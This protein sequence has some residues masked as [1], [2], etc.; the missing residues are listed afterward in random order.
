MKNVGIL[1]IGTALSVEAIFTSDS[2]SSRLE[3]KRM[4]MMPRTK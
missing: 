2:V 4:L 3:S 1:F